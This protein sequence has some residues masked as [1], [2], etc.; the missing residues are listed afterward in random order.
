MNYRIFLGRS[1]FRA[2]PEQAMFYEAAADRINNAG[3]DVPFVADVTAWYFA[4][5]VTLGPDKKVRHPGALVR[6]MIFS[7]VPR[8]SEQVMTFEECRAQL[9]ATVHEIR[10]EY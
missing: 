9:N 6:Y 1:D 5:E 8:D 3:E 10:N 4:D 7:A 2:S